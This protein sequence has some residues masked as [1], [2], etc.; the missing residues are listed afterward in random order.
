MIPAYPA[1]LLILFGLPVLLL[2]QIREYRLNRQDLMKIGSILEDEKVQSVFFIKWFLS[3]ICLVL[4]YVFFVFSLA[5]LSWGEEPV[6]E[7]RLGID[8]MYLVDVS[9]S[10]LA[11]DVK[12]N[13]LERAKEIIQGLSEKIV[14]ARIGL[15]AFK[16]SGTMLLPATEDIYAL[17][18]VLNALNTEVI[19]TPG[20]NLEAALSKTIGAFPPGSN[21]HRV[22]VLFSDGEILGGSSNTSALFAA[23]QGIPVFSYGLGSID[24]APIPQGEGWVMK[25]GKTVISRL[26]STGLRELARLTRG[27][28]FEAK[29]GSDS[30]SKAINKLAGQRESD[31][32]RI[33]NIFRYRFFLIF[34]L[35]SYVAHILIRAVEIKGL[36]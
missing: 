12:P 10:M 7:D 1:N 22:I 26:N 3:A 27:S 6:E 18:N 29:A 30:L 35:I 34:V 33:M 25:N 4:V 28:Y 31:G 32:F 9:Y 8:V 19:S 2:F 23:R 15:V 13:R 24:G 11:Q 21:R 14:G 16:G 5:D 17:D 36:F 20:S